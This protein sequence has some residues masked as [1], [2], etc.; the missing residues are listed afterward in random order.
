MAALPFREHSSNLSPRTQRLPCLQAVV[1]AT[2][3]VLQGFD[4]LWQSSCS[5]E[6]VTV[7]A[8]YYTEVA[9]TKT[10]DPPVG[11]RLA[12]PN[13]KCVVADI[14]E[15]DLDAT[16]KEWIGLVEK[17]A[18]LARIRLNF[19]ERTGH[20]PKLLHE[21]IAR[22]RLDGGTKAPQS[23][24]AH[25]HG[26]LRRKQGYS[27]A[28]VVDESRILQVC[29]FSTLHRNTER[30]NFQKLLPDVVII[31]DEVDAQLKQQVLCFMDDATKRPKA[32]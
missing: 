9:M 21:V 31:A 32:G 23:V 26:Q 25:H 18:D 10:A 1:L 20:L 7:G 8:E 4:A 24:A 3:K 14:L 28:M 6:A 13:T 30:V 19:E 27:V 11:F 17:D 12:P 5:Q 29:I 2:N 22:L 15:R 16:I